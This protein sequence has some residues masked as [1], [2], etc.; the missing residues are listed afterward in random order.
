[1]LTGKNAI[2]LQAA[3]YR[4]EKLTEGS[5]FESAFQYK[6]ETLMIWNLKGYLGSDRCQADVLRRLRGSRKQ[7]K[8]LQKEQKGGFG[9]ISQTGASGMGNNNK[10]LG[11]GEK[12]KRKHEAFVDKME[13]LF[14]SEVL[15]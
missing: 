1:M 5:Y 15:K 4:T 9:Q 7:Q 6:G 2:T 11:E 10:R 3:Y 14:K 12:R 13:A 8:H